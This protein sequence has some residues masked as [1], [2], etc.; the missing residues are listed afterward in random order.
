MLNTFPN[1]HYTLN[2]DEI[3][4][5]SET[6]KST[7]LQFCMDTYWLTSNHLKLNATKT[8]LFNINANSK[9]DN[10]PILFIEFSQLTPSSTVKYIGITLNPKLDS[11]DHITSLI[12]TTSH[13]QYN[14]RKIRPFIDFPTAKLLRYSLVLS[15]LNY[16]NTF[17]IGTKTASITK[18]DRI[19]NRS[20]RTIYQLKTTD[21][22]T[23]VT[24]LR[25]QL[26]W[27]TTT[28][29]INYKTLTPLHN[30]DSHRTHSNI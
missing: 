16:C 12:K 30:T 20:L 18:L 13:F 14:I 23:F 17:L 6:T 7:E 25:I 2:A 24:N 21:Y 22:T 15:R 1:V 19:I 10:F 11:D 3:E 9:L 29:Q 4:L 28:Q 5:Y 27:L 8:E 26:I